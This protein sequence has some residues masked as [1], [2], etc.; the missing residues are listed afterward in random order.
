MD[1]E[2]GIINRRNLT[3]EINQT[4]SM[5]DQ[6][7][8]ELRESSQTNNIRLQNINDSA[9]DERDLRSKISLHRLA[10]DRI[11]VIQNSILYMDSGN[12]GICCDCDDH[13]D[14]RRLAIAPESTLCISC[15]VEREKIDHLEKQKFITIPGLQNM[16]ISYFAS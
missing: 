16:N 7:K 1:V 12:Y 6:L 9:S 5:A 14:E 15:Q 11:K 10:M 8:K 2:K 4:Q 13:I 3:E